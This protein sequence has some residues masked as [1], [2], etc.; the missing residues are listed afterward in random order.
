MLTDL[1]GFGLLIPPI[2]RWVRGWLGR[3]LRKRIVVIRP[4]DPGHSSHDQFIDVPGSGYDAGE[5]SQ[6]DHR[7][8]G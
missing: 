1:C 2:R 8:D 7:L 6:E 4:G 5:P 3:M